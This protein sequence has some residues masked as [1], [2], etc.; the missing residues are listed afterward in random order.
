VY[1]AILINVTKKNLDLSVQTV[2]SRDYAELDLSVSVT[3][4]PN[5]D[6]A[7][8]YLNQGEEQGV[9][10]ILTD[11]IRE[12]L[13]EWAIDLNWQEAINAKDK[14]AAMLI[15][16]ISGLNPN[17]TPKE[18][19]K[20]VRVIRL[21]NGAQVVSSLGITL[22]RLNISDIKLKGELARAAE[23]LVKEHQE[24]EGEKVELE[25]VLDR[26]TEIVKRL[27]CS[28]TQAIELLQAERGKVAKMIH[29]IKGSVSDDVIRTIERIIFARKNRS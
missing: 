4:T 11:I 5:S 27:N 22:N 20:A 24:R 29:E 17:L 25:H 1:D 7:L 21:G 9:R 15:R 6:F 26:V 18:L 2:R 3:W 19:E 14:A 12:R 13:R 10:N 8:E 16:E 28:Y 23:L